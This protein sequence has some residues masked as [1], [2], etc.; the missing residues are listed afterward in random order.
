V[1][2]TS[3]G[4]VFS[5]HPTIRQ[6][7]AES[8]LS[9]IPVVGPSLTGG[10]LQGNGM[11]LAVGLAGALWAGL[12][13]MLAGQDA[14]NAVWDV[15]IH[16]RPNFLLSRVRAVLMLGV[17]G[18]QLLGATVLS[19]L[20][21]AL[22]GLNGAAQFGIAVGNIALNVFVVGLAFKVL[23]DRRLS[24][25]QLWPGALLAGVGYFALQ[26]IGTRVVAQRISAASDVYGTFAT[27]IGLLTYFYLLAQI[28]VF[29]A[30][31]NVVR[32]RHLY[33]RNLF[34]E[35]H[36]EADHRAEAAYAREARR[37]KSISLDAERVDGR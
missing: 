37:T 31:I 20:G 13:A 27:V 11:G 26:T 9:Q 30:E 28:T 33:P 24:V 17:L 23:T 32:D 2:V 1:L 5:G 35:D 19:A 25:G 10:S 29:A 15:P 36:T 7:I 14:M 21:T 4:F 16:D 34:G 8:A 12:G 22:P 3:L 6:D 18:I